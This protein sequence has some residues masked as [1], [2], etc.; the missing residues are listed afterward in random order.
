MGSTTFASTTGFACRFST[1]RG[2]VMSPE[3]EVLVATTTVVP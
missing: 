1:V 2:D 3:D